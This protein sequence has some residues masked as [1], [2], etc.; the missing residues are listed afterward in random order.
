MGFTDALVLMLA[1]VTAIGNGIL[2]QW[3]AMS[4]NIGSPLDANATLTASGQE[5]AG[6]L[7]SAAVIT[8][9]IIAVLVG[10]LF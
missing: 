2:S 5:M 1:E 8:S 6:Y 9:D 10:A 7:A 4:A 3:V